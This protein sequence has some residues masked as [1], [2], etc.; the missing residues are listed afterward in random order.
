MQQLPK[1]P[2]PLLEQTIS[3]YLRALKPIL[4]PQHYERTKNIAKQFSTHPG[5]TL[6]QYLTDKRENEDNW[7]SK[8]YVFSLD[9]KILLFNK[10]NL[11]DEMRQ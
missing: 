6:H 9:L 3:E 11:F 7:V 10:V 5:P 8:R 2:V 1:V 4:T